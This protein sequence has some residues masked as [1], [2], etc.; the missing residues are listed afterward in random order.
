MTHLSRSYGDKML[1][2]MPE[3][4]ADYGDRSDQYDEGEYD[5]DNSGSGE[6]SIGKLSSIASRPHIDFSICLLI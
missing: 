3:G 5:E 4:S 2:D 6:H 1:S